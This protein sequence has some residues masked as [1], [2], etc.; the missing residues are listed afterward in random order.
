LKWAGGKAQ[1]LTQFDSFFPKSIKSYV[2][3]FVGG[4]AV[5]FHLKANF[6]AMRAALFDINDE[7]INA[8]LVVRDNPEGLMNRLD[9]HFSSYQR[10]PKHYYY[11]VRSNHGIEDKVDRAARVVFLNKTCFNGLWRVNARGEFNVP[12]GSFKRVTLYDR[13][14]IRAASRALKGG[15]IRWQ[16][17]RKT[18]RQVK[19]GD[20]VYV[21]PPYHPLSRTSA[22]TA[23]TKDDFGETEQEELAALFAEA[24][25]RGAQLMLSNSDTKFIRDLYRDFLIHPVK[26]RRAINCR[27]EGRGTVSEVVVTTYRC[28]AD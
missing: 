21:D 20:F 16:D 14:N 13:E 24:A 15:D 3:P 25:N 8:F 5:F 1:L 19:K 28:A 10:D 18:L 27:G 6:P 7:I 17:F 11:S 9:E 4:G 22:F 26:A 2:E 12:I 23:Y